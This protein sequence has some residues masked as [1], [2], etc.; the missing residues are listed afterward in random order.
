MGKVPRLS[1]SRILLVHGNLSSLPSLITELP[2]ECGCLAQDC[3]SQL[4]LQVGFRQRNVLK[5]HVCNFSLISW[6]NISGTGS[7][8]FPLFL[9]AGADTI[10]LALGAIYWR[11]QSCINLAHWM[12]VWRTASC[13]NW[14]C[15]SHCDTFVI[16]LSVSFILHKTLN[17]YLLNID[18]ALGPLYVKV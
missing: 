1:V 12:S 9:L 3:R 4:P 18:Y 16:V 17:K 2:L 15:F 11:E 8:L 7:P 10:K 6:G 14:G 5:M 13:C